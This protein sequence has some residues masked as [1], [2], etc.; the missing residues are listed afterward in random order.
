[1][2]KRRPLIYCCR[3]GKGEETDL[4]AF[5]DGTSFQLLNQ[6]RLARMKAEQRVWVGKILRKH[7]IAEDTRYQN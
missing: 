3:G 2:M 7:I 4:M 6:A 1:M 5:H